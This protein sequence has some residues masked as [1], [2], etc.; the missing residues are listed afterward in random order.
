MR[1]M[2]AATEMMHT[3]IVSESFYLTKT[4]TLITN[5]NSCF[6][7]LLIIGQIDRKP[8]RLTINISSAI[9]QEI[10][11]VLDTKVWEIFHKKWGSAYS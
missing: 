8:L 4:V 5:S 11:S 6:F 1:F 7:F 3:G 2:R 10:F 9:S